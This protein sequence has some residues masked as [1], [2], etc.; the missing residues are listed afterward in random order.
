MVRVAFLALFWGLVG[1]VDDGP[2]RENGG[3]AS[4]RQCDGQGPS[5]VLL[6]RKITFSRAEL[7]VSEGFDLDGF[8]SGTTDPRGCYVEDFVD[9]DGVEG[10]DNSMARLLPVLDN[11]E[12]AALEPIVQDSINGGAL[13][14]MVELSDLDNTED[15]ACVDIDIFKGFGQPMIGNDGWLLANQTL[16]IDPESPVT[17]ASSHF[18][19]GRLEAGPID[20][21]ALP[22]QVLD[23]DSTLELFNVRMR[24]EPGEDGNWTG[25]LAGGLEVDDIVDTATLQNV[26]PAV[27]DLIGPVLYAVSDLAPDGAGSCEQLS[28]TMELDLVPAFVYED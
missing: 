12:A 4:Q 27:F 21:V 6:T 16:V 15:D 1:C 8:V 18:E 17:P 28:V 9:P 23:L 3:A 5:Q 22:I 25:I 20:V 10:I 24:L 19:G 26:D 7:D 11:T 2:S 14:L 13:L